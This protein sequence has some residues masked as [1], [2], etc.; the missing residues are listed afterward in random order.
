MVT[1][2]KI[3]LILIGALVAL[4][5]VVLIG[6]IV[7]IR[8]SVLPMV[9]SLTGCDASVGRVS[10]GT[11]SSYIVIQDLKII[12]PSDFVEKRLLNA[13]EIYIE[14][15]LTSLLSSHMKFPKIRLKIEEVVVVKNEK[16]ESNLARSMASKSKSEGR[17][18]VAST[19]TFFGEVDLSLGRVIHI[20]Y[21]KVSGG[22]PLTKETTLNYHFTYRD[23]SDS[24][25]KKIV[26]QDVLK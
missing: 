25:L 11:F 20:D 4:V 26:M 16:G 24:D 9:R 13:P 22:K 21:S 5:F 18:G 6:R 14:Y 19:G 23:L 7:I 2:R 17:G 1:L 8:M 10:V 12:N 15:K 3:V